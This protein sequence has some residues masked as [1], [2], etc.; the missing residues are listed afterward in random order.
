MN[1]LTISIV[2]YHNDVNHI[3]C[4]MDSLLRCHWCSDVYFLD[5]SSTNKLESYIHDNFHYQWNRKNSGFGQGHCA[6][7]DNTLNYG[8]YH[9]VMNPDVF[10]D[11]GIIEKIILFMDQYEDIG[12]LLPRVLNPD[13]TEQPLYKLL[14]RPQD[15]IL[16][17]FL[18]SRLKKRFDREL[19]RYSM[20]FADSSTT[21]DAPYLS[22]CFMFMRK[23]ALKDVG[24]FDPRFF[25]YC[26]D[27]DLS[28]RIRMKW[29]T[30]YYGEATIYHYFYKGSYKELR[31]LYY[32][33]LSAIK[34]FN[35]YGWLRDAERVRINNET[36]DGYLLNRISNDISI[37]ES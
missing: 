28:R 26:E 34:Y 33:L 3:K 5:N 27:I 22:G 15:L 17:R 12:L 29:R 11:V 2:L 35:K 19:D 25:M 8:D 30:T 14:P 1:R 9:L 13:K 31:L 37:N 4:L 24:S 6:I 23:Q 36:L 10:F 21:F 18:P 20:S 32:H 7:I 16:R